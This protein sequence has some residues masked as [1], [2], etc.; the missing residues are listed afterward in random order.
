[1][2]KDTYTISEIHLQVDDHH[3][4]YVQEWGN[5]KGLPIIYLHGGPGGQV[6]DKHKN[7]FDPE[8]HRVVFFD[9]RGC[10]QSMPLGSIEKNTTPDL[11]GDI[12]KIA[13]HFKIDTFTLYGGSWGSC[14][15]LAYA[16]TRPK[17]VANL[18]LTGIFSG[19]SEEINWVEKGQFRTFYPEAWIRY[20]EATPKA[21]HDNP[22]K[23]HFDKI[24]NGSQK[25]QKQSAY[26]Y[27]N[28]EG[29]VVKLDDRFAAEDYDNFEPGG[30]RIEVHYL[31]NKCFMPS[32]NY[33]LE[34][35]HTLDMPVVM[36]QGRYDMVCPPKTAFEL[37]K[38][39]SNSQ[40]ITTLSGHIPEHEDVQLLR[41][42]LRTL[43][44]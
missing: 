40:L 17:R 24:L 42:A 31:A 12:S 20:L 28:L 38:K 37:H 23:Y 41:Q 32:S 10:G 35:A 34:R 27:Q 16:I 39:L 19:S 26:A 14:L 18:I 30:V 9:Q 15:A 22:S 11:I 13:D 3:T 5:P 1:M 7:L 25:E 33:I 8:L 44:K 29:Y 4:L 2:N 36:V 6:K 21:H 43:T